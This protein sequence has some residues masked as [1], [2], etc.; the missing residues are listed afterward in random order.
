VGVSTDPGRFVCNY[1]YYCSLQQQ[2]QQQQRQ[3][4]QAVSNGTSL[5]VHV[6]SF[7]VIS[8][9]EQRQFVQ[10]LL[11]EVRPA[12]HVCCWLHSR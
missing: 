7:D 9:E 12:C 11:L 2:Q 5:F 8:E 3:Q 4:Q 10:D 1:L 6:P